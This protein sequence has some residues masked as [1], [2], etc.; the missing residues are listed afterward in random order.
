MKNCIVCKKEFSKESSYSYKQ[1]GKRMFCSN[2]CR[3]KYGMQNETKDK[4]SKALTGRK[5]SKEHIEKIAFAR[6]GMKRSEFTKRKTSESLLKMYK[7]RPELRN[8]KRETA[9]R[10]G[11][12]PPTFRGSHHTEKTRKK[13]SEYK[14]TNK[15]RNPFYKGGISKI[16]DLIR[17]SFKS[18]LWREAVFARDNWTC[19][20]CGVKGGNL[21]AHHIKPF[22]QYP[23]LRL[24]TD[25]GITLCKECHRKT[26]SWGINQFTNK[27]YIQLN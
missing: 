5:L 22:S 4:L 2:L 24:A 19:Q 15:E 12:N 27:N 7:E 1:W 25:N 10:L 21:N 14:I 13:M 20:T 6:R 23:E 18:K 26:E 8:Q 9:I 3:G 11:I 16:N 17:K